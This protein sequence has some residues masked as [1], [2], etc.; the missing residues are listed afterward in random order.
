[1]ALYCLCNNP[2]NGKGRIELEPEFVHPAV[3]H[4]RAAAERQRSLGLIHA[5]GMDV[6][7]R[8]AAKEISGLIKAADEGDDRAQTVLYELALPFCAML[9]MLTVQYC[10]PD[11]ILPST[12][13]STSVTSKPR[14]AQW[15]A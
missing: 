6:V 10:A 14:C 12:S 5:E 2:F 8:I 1:L 4:D 11:P 9:S 7:M 13:F 15:R 3:A